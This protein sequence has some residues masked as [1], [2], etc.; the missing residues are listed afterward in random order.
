MADTTTTNLSL[1]KPEVGASADTW[2]T[3]L[4]TNLDTIDA[5]LF[6]STELTPDL[7]SGAWEIGGVA[8]TPTA[9]ELNYVKGVTSGIQAQINAK[10]TTASYT[11]L[12]AIEALTGTGLPA[13]QAD[14]VWALRSIVAGTATSVLNGA[15]AAGNP[16]INVVFAD[17]AEAEAGTVSDEAMSP[18]RTAQAIAAQVVPACGV[19]QTWQDVSASRAGS[20]SYQNT[21]GQPIMVSVT[22]NNGTN[23]AFQVS[24]DDA[25]WVTVGVVGSNSEHSFAFIVPDTHYYRVNGVISATYWAELS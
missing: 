17:Q 6:G 24:T 25:T 21:T 9:A 2:G 7:Q 16:T 19:G 13:K 23:P 14:G 15:G 12:T 3:K 18:L 20:T 11:D 22:D 5:A 10:M 4:N 1:T 8:V